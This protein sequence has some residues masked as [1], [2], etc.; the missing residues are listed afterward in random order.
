MLPPLSDHS[1]Y[2]RDLIISF[3]VTGH[4]TL[5]INAMLRLQSDEPKNEAMA[6][7]HSLLT[8]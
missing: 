2:L 6:P 4:F 3:P 8:L 7:K 5:V 1:G